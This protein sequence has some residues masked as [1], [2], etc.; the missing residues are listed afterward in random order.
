MVED[1]GV[2]GRVTNKTRRRIAITRMALANVPRNVMCQIIGHK[3]SNS[4]DRYDDS[5]EVGHKAPMK[6]IESLVVE[7]DQGR[8]GQYSTP[9]DRVAEVFCEHQCVKS[10][11]N[12]MYLNVELKVAVFPSNPTGIT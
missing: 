7:L 4:L 12:S 10:P 5:L 9:K 11:S 2:E 8:I 3:N 6:T 1:A